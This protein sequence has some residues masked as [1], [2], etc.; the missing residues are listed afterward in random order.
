[1]IIAFPSA[2]CCGSPAFVVLLFAAGTL[3]RRAWGR[4]SSGSRPD[5]QRENGGPDGALT[6]AGGEDGVFRR[7]RERCVARGGSGRGRVVFAL[8][9]SVTLRGLGV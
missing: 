1:M 4:K 3:F 5:C 8:R 7:G 2:A 6:S 9:V